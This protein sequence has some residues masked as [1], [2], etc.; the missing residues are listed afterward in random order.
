[1]LCGRCTEDLYGLSDSLYKRYKNVHRGRS[2]DTHVRGGLS[3]TAL[4]TAT[5]ILAS[6]TFE[7]PV[8]GSDCVQKLIVRSFMQ[9]PDVICCGLLFAKVEEHRVSVYGI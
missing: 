4:M 8:G 9:E 3:S 6:L 5:P 1:M 2:R 7:T